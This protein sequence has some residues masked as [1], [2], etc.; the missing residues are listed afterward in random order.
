MKLPGMLLLAVAAITFAA[1]PAWAQDGD[2]S[3]RRDALFRQMFR[4]PADLDLMLAY[5]RVSVDLRDYEQVVATLERALDIQPDAVEARLDLAV[6]YYA[7]GA[8]DLAQYHLGVVA[9][10]PDL[11]PDLAA[12]VARYN[13]LAEQR[14]G[15]SSVSGFVEAGVAG[16]LV[17][18]E[19]GFEFGFG[20]VWRVQRDGAQDSRWITELNGRM[21]RFPDDDDLSFG[22]LSLR[23]GPEFSVDGTAYGLRLRPYLAAATSVDFDL[24]QRSTL[25]AG[26]L[27]GNSYSD[28][29]SGFAVLEGG[30]LWREDPDAE[31]GYGLLQAGLN[32]Y[33]APDT[34]LRLSLRGRRDD[35]D[36]DAANVQSYGARLDLRHKFKPQFSRSDRKWQVSAYV[37]ADRQDYYSASPD[38]SDDLFGY[39]AAIRAYVVGDTYL[40]LRGDRLERDTDIDGVA[41]ERELIGLLLGREF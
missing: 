41:T 25:G 16:A 21:L 30:A 17:E 29:V 40:E 36:A 28:S 20:L 23:T 7:L 9:T 3:A 8:Y 24:D 31:G 12:E 22:A 19:T 6:A 34:L 11:P 5:A 39:G 1:P 26:M 18:E 2:L 37:L 13:A 38:R 14:A 10:A 35:T 4:A 27:V 32:I 33:P 15:D